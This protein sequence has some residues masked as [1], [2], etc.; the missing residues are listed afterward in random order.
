MN[1]LKKLLQVLA[2]LAAIAAAAAA[3]LRLIEL[4]N[5]KM[6]ELDAYLTNDPEDDVEQS[7]AMDAGEDYVE[8]DLEEWNHLG[9]D[10]NVEL[11]LMMDPA[12]V[13][14]AQDELAAQGYSSNYDQDSKILDIQISGPR[15]HQEIIDLEDLIKTLLAQSNGTYLGFAF[16]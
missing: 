14:K 5:E 9:D 8:Q 12:F 15:D 4:H 7:G 10:Q 13:E 11:S 3:I 16:L 1:F 6:D 2:A